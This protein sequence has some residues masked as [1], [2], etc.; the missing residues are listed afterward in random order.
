VIPLVA[1]RRP[2]HR[3][4]FLCSFPASP[5]EAL[6][7]GVGEEPTLT[8]PRALG[9]RSCLDEEGRYV[10]PDFESA[11]YAMYH[12][13]PAEGAAAAFAMLRPQA[14]LPFVERYPLESWPPTPVSFIV[15]TDDR[16]GSSDA[17]GRVART[18]FGVEAI[19]LP[20]SHSPFLSR[21]AA[22][23]EVLCALDD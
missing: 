22:L 12:D 5:G 13:C 3:L 10:W 20:G 19:E 9:W 15:C 17:L 14:R 21:P 4:V 7:D 2:I 1:T 11:C 23:A 8:D 18:R 16:L 6:D